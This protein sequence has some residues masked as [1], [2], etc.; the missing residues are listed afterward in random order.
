MEE[1]GNFPLVC[2]FDSGIGGLNLLNVC[3][4]LRSDCD[5]A[6]FSDNKNVPYGSLSNAKISALAISHFDRMARLNPRAC[7]VACNTVTAECIGLLRSRYPF[8][9]VGIQPAVK[10]AAASAENCIVLATPATAA[11]EPLKKL[12]TLYGR[13]NTRVLPCPNLAAYIEENFFNLDKNEIFKLLPRAKAGAVVLGCTHYV[14]ASETI[15]EFYNCK[16]FDG[17]EGTAA[18]LC[19]ILG[20]NDHFSARIQKVSFLSG[21][22]RKNARIWRFLNRN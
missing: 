13:G 15:K 9:I 18:R 20:K 3:A 5:F 2:F 14:Y 1:C 8:P 19:K 21:N 4:K 11:A 7:V 16:I 10:P 6:Y 12:V 17:I 22:C